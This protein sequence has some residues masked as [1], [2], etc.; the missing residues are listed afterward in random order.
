[1]RIRCLFIEL[2]EST[3]FPTERESSG[4]LQTTNVGGAALSLSRQFVCRVKSNT[5]C[6]MKCY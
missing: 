6:P 2:D 5:V 4:R 3:A 1:M